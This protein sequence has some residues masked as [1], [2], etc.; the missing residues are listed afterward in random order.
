MRLAFV[1]FRHGHAMGLYTAAAGHA[2]MQIVA[3]CEE[4]AQ[5]AQALQEGGK[6]RVTHQNYIDMLDKVPC[7]A[8]GVGDY[9][10][11]RGRIV[12][13]ALKRGKHVIADKP[14]CTRRSELEEIAAIA[15]ARRLRVGCLLD[16]RGGGAVRTVRRLIRENTIGEIHTV[17]FLAQHPLIYASRPAWYWVPGMQ[18]GTINDIAIHAL[19]II[20]WV[21]GRKI[22]EVTA[23]RGWNARL[24]QHP[25]F[26]DG[27]QIMLKLDNGGGVMGD[28]SYLAPDGCGYTVPQ[29]WRMTFHGSGGML[30]CGMDSVPVMLARDADK[31][32]QTLPPDPAVPHAALNSFLREV[33]GMEGEIAPTTLEVLEASRVALIA[34]E[35]ADKNLR[36]VKV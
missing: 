31:Q 14:I 29:Y 30:E 25:H 21:T 4:D 15:A 6:V 7:D 35:A 24:P 20:P 36:D 17:T 12:L 26:Q 10:E 1:G 13:E 33:E 28:V 8:V 5:T 32:P 3:A 27:A 22:V 19:D 18:G 2:G 23:A 9:F 16:L 11:K 34:Q